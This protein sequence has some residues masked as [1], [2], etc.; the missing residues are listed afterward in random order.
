MNL[1]LRLRRSD[2]LASLA[3][4]LAAAGPA[5]APSGRFLALSDVHFDPFADP[6]IVPD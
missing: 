6:S 1:D 5:P 4:L 3:L 2:T